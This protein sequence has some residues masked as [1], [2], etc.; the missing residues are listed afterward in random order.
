MSAA[1]RGRKACP[2][3]EEAKLLAFLD[4]IPVRV[5][6][7]GSDRRHLYANREYAEAIGMP[8]EEFIGKTIADIFGAESYENLKPFGDRALAGE[9]LECEGW[10]KHP[11]LG[12]RYA[13]RVYRPYTRPDGTVE[14]FLS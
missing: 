7:I 6:F 5:A 4:D 2:G 9:S 11:Q 8:A 12:D 1:S 10:I 14:R 13:R 3:F